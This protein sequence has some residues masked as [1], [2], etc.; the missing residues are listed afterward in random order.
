[1]LKRIHIPFTHFFFLIRE[2][3]VKSMM[4]K[5]ERSK[6]FGVK[7]ADGQEL[8]RVMELAASEFGGCDVDTSSLFLFLHVDALQTSIIRDAV[9]LFVV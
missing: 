3:K 7:A 9:N 2:S 8:L 5:R 4:M 6:Q 1:M